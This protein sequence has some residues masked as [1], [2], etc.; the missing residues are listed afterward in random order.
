MDKKQYDGIFVSIASDSLP[1]GSVMNVLL[2]VSVWYSEIMFNYSYNVTK[3][4]DP[5]PSLDIDGIS[6]FGNENYQ[7]STIK[8]DVDIEFEYACDNSNQSNFD[9]ELNWVVRENGVT[10]SDDAVADVY[11]FDLNDLSLIIDKEYLNVGSNYEFEVRMACGGD[12][13]CDITQTHSLFYE[14]SDLVCQ[15]AGGNKYISDVTEET[16]QSFSFELD[17]SIFSYD[18]DN[19]EFLKFEWKCALEIDETEQECNEFVLSNIDGASTTVSL[20]NE[21]FNDPNV[22][23]IYRFEMTMY[24]SANEATREPCIA[25]S[26]LAI[27]N[28]Y[29]DS[30]NGD[31]GASSDDPSSRATI[32]DI[33]IAAANTQ[34]NVNDKLRLIVN[35]NSGNEDGENV[36]Y[37][38]YNFE[39]SE[40][41]GYLTTQEIANF[42]INENV[43]SNYLIL[44]SNSLSEGITY[45]FEVKVSKLDECGVA[46]ISIYVN[47]GPSVVDNSFDILPSGICNGSTTYYESFTDLFDNFYDISIGA[48]AD[49][50]P[51]QFQFFYTFETDFDE[52][53][54]WLDS[55]VSENAFMTGMCFIC[56]FVL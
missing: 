8:I 31:N 30:D 38:S 7:S 18:P 6:S 2:Q 41:N 34:M 55:S 26:F 13:Y 33:S 20:Q 27:T 16:L 36:N 40:L 1:I 28:V 9:Y 47:K 53:F 44:E 45:E 43:E 29:A 17:G 56:S 11:S 5:V 32:L 19:S 24:D 39:W 4:N 14:F 25:N 50:T 54:W 37:A 21:T 48:N 22:T 46:S 49:N 12:Y 35:V 51:L 23:Y 15:T 3:S 42:Q 10:M 52:V